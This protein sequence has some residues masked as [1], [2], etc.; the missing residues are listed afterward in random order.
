M[1]GGHFNY[2]QNR[3]TEVMEEIQELMD[4]GEYSAEVID[5]MG[6]GLRSVQMAQCFITRIDWLASGDDGE[7]SFLK[8]LDSELDMIVE[9]W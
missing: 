8:R 4:S 5:K 6:E 9:S 1:S 3:L 2:I 7:E